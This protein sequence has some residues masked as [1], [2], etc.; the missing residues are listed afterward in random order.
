MWKVEGNVV[1]IQAKQAIFVR[2]Y[3]HLVITLFTHAYALHAHMQGE[4]CSSYAFGIVAALEGSQAL[5]TGELVSLSEQ[6]VVD[7]S[8]MNDIIFSVVISPI[9]IPDCCKLILIP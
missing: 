8:G 6:N 9:P 1:Y 5:A 4:C 3:C 7:C 2:W